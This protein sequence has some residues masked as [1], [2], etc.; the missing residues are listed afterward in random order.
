MKI[1]KIILLNSS[2]VFLILTVTIFNLA[3]AQK[4]YFDLSQDEINIKTNFT[5]Q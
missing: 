5:G 1:K 3:Y 2:I 4:A